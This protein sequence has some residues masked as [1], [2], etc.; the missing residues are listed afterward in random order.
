MFLQ[1]FA[2][3]DSSLNHEDFKESLRKIDNQNNK[4]TQKQI[5]PA[6][7]KFFKIEMP[8]TQH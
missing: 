3:I 7:C 6:I 4:L 8:E 1:Q 5:V 2:V